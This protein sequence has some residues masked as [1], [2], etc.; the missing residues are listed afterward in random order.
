MTMENHDLE[1]DWTWRLSRS[2]KLYIAAGVAVVCVMISVMLF[3]ALKDVLRMMAAA[4]RKPDRFKH[5][6]PRVS[7]KRGPEHTITNSKI[8]KIS[9]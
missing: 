5:R 6:P 1:D 7:G 4:I 8:M 3:A 2:Q 9:K